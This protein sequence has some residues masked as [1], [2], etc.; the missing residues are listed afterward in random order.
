MLHFRLWLVRANLLHPFI[1]ISF[2]DIL[3]EPILL[4]DSSFKLIAFASKLVEIVIR[5]MTPRLL[6]FPL[7][8]LPVGFYLTSIPCDLH[9]AKAM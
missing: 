2:R 4:L 5:K 1:D 6:S 9:I 7:N 8:F 3:A